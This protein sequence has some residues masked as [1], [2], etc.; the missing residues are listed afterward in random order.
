MSSWH[1]HGSLGPPVPTQT[2]L[3]IAPRLLP[4]LIVLFSTLL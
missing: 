1:V 4:E 3:P 2:E